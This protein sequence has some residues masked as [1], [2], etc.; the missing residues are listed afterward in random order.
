M[1]RGDVLVLATPGLKSCPVTRKPPP[2]NRQGTADGVPDGYVFRYSPTCSL[3][4]SSGTQRD[5]PSR[6]TSSSLHSI[7]SY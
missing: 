2:V 5:L 7:R 6:N 4:I 3:P 1:D